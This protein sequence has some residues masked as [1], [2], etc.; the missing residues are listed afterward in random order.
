M[1][2]HIFHHRC[3]ICMEELHLVNGEWVGHDPLCEATG[4]DEPEKP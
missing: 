3:P 2:D 1:T 4:K